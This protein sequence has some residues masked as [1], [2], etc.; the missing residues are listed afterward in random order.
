MDGFWIDGINGVFYEMTGNS[1]QE[2]G[3]IV[4]MKVSK[5]SKMILLHKNMYEPFFYVRFGHKS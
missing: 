4:L 5:S 1:S 3:C 2:K